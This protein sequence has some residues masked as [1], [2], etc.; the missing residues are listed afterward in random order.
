MLVVR[1]TQKSIVRRVIVPIFASETRT[2]GLLSPK[3]EIINNLK[4]YDYENDAIK[5]DDSCSY[6]EHRDGNEFQ[7][8]RQEVPQGH[9]EI[10]Y[11]DQ[12]SI[13]PLC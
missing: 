4:T 6:R 11:R 10:P 2:T 13:P 7:E 3:K 12:S 1:K 5:P 8:C 9:S